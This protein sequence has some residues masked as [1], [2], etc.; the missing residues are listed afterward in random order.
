LGSAIV[1]AGAADVGFG[2]VPVAARVVV[3][4]VGGDH[5]AAG[6]RQLVPIAAAAD[7]DA[8]GAGIAVKDCTGDIVY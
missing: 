2:A 5:H 7:I 4:G 8:V 3:F 1:F 6:H